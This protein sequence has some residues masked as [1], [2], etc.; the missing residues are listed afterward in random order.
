ML[1]YIDILIIVVYLGGTI[2]IGILC[3]GKQ[4]DA[5]DYFT[6]KG[7]MRGFFSSILVGLSIA[8]TL[9]SGIS[10]LGLPSVVYDNGIGILLQLVNFFVAW[11]VLVFWFLPR[12]LNAHDTRHPYD[13]IEQQ[14]GPII[15]TLAASMYVLLR[16]G[17]MAALIYAPTIAI[18]AAAGF[19]GQKYFWT[20]VLT[21]GIAS[22][23]Y[24]TLGGIRGVIITDAIQFVVIAVGV[25]VTIAVM[26]IRLPVSIPELFSFLQEN[27]RL[28]LLDFSPD[29]TKL[30]TVWSILI[31]ANIANFGMYMADQ[32]S[33]Q[34][35]LATGSI[36][37]LN[38][39]FMANTIGIIIVLILLGIVGL[40]LF[41]WYHYNPDPDI[42]KAV[43]KIFP[44]FVATQLPPG[45]AGLILAAI[46]AATMSSITSGINALSATLSLDFR[47]RMGKPMT[48]KQ[49]LWFGKKVSLLVGLVATFAAGL[50]QSFGNIFEITQSLLGLFLGPLLTCMFFAIMKKPVHTT[51]LIIGLGAGLVVGSCVSFSPIAQTWVPAASFFVSFA[52]ACAGTV[53]FGCKKRGT[54]K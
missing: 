38:R 36:R 3:R 54:C 30:I 39:S 42:P 53:I 5:E 17:W 15:R 35:Y 18:M 9:F 40:V 2:A 49:Q 16:I 14:L 13:I 45:V 19:E 50:V 11:L 41:A 46:L 24:T 4:E 37:S 44:Y 21:I 33:L 26:L 28:T 32:M 27:N 12:Y 43:D 25:S 6:T 8:A 20:I 48:P 23:I 51:S 7:R 34:R 52:L 1:S 31:G 47:A 29:P 22:T 10:F